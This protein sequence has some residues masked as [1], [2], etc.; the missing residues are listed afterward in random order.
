MNLISDHL[1]MNLSRRQSM[2]L[3]LSRVSIVCR[4]GRLWITEAVGRDDIILEAGQ[5][6][7]TS[8]A[9]TLIQALKEARFELQA[10]AARPS[11]AA[12]IAAQMRHTG[13]FSAAEGCRPAY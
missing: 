6:Y 2:T 12:R 13:G 11:L 4:S 1:N 3:A 10:P 9:G 7:V 5:A 8:H